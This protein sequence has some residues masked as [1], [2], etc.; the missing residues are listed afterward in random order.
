MR[1]HNL[2]IALGVLVVVM[3]VYGY[4]PDARVFALPVFLLLAALVALAFGL[5]LAVV[6][7][8]YRD[9]QYLLPWALQL[10]MFVS[11]VGFASAAV[12][13]QWQFLYGL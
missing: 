5:W 13:E 8:Y 4:F 7:V 6:N 11:P 3:V 1:F 9:F 12:P 2:V 10:A